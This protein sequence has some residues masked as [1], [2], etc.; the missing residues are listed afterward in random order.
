LAVED[1][2]RGLAA[3]RG[4]GLRC[5]IVPTDL[6]RDCAFAGAYRVVRTAAEIA[7]LC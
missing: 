5:V 6:T 2:E 4:A 1:S 3:A 7:S